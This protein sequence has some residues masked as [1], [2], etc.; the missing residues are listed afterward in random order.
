VFF[1]PNSPVQKE[2]GVFLSFTT[3]YNSHRDKLSNFAT[4][5]QQQKKSDDY[6]CIALRSFNSYLLK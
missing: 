5:L 4:G 2:M 6:L 1:I 3:L